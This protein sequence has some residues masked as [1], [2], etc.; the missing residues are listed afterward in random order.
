MADRRP[1]ELMANVLCFMEQ[2][3]GE[4]TPSS[5]EVL[6]QA[7]RLGS[8]LGATVYAALALERAPGYGDDDVLA[9]LASAGADKVLLL[10]GEV[11]GGS[12]EE[13]T[14]ETHG[15]A[16]VAA[17]DVSQPTIMLVPAV[18]CGRELAAR[19]AARV[20]AA[21]LHDAF[22]EVRDGALLLAEPSAD[23]SR[24]LPADLDYP[25]VAT[26]PPGRYAVAAGDEEAE[27]E[28]LQ[29]AP[30]MRFSV[31]ASEDETAPVRAEV[32]RK[33]GI[34]IVTLETGK[35]RLTIATGPNAREVPADFAVEGDAAPLIEHLVGRRS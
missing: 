21:F 18:G 34:A 7:R 33:D 13:P 24:R 14:W 10:V 28:V 11:F 29:V 35:G 20:G 16:M 30:L 19:A 4:L 23:G 5:L 3:A 9:R 31:E 6:G 8:E 26:I 12:A 2:H 22:V 25:V 15:P 32:T 27:V 17:W 1:G